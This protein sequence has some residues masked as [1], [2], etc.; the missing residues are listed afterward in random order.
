MTFCK[1]NKG[2]I[3]MFALIILVVIA[4]I[5]LSMK[6]SSQYSSSSSR[7]YAARIK[8]FSASDGVMTLLAQDMLDFNESKYNFTL[9]SDADIGSPSAAGSYK[10]GAGG[11]DTVKGDGS[12]FGGITQTSDKFHFAYCSVSGDFQVYVQVKSIQNTNSFAKAAL[13]IRQSTD[14]NAAFFHAAIAYGQGYFV[15][16]RSSAGAAAQMPVTGSGSVPIWFRITRAGNVF[17]AEKS[18]NGSTWTT[19]TSQTIAMGTQ[20]LAGLGV[21]SYSS[22]NLCTAVFSNLTGL[23]SSTASGQM[24]VGDNQIPVDYTITKTGTNSFDLSTKAYINTSSEKLFGS[25]LNQSIS[26]ETVGKYQ[27]TVHD[28]AFI[29]VTLY[30]FR[31]DQTCPEFNVRGTISLSAN[32]NVIATFIQNTLDSDFKP[33]IKKDAAFR[34]CFI[35][36]FGST[37][38]SLPVATRIWVCSNPDSVSKVAC[39]YNNGNKFTWDFCD[40]MHTWFRPWGDSTGKTGTY[41]FSRTT[42]RWTGLKKRL[43]SSGLPTSDSGWVSAHWDST[44]AFANIVFYDSLKFRELPSPDTGI[45]QFGDSIHAWGVDSQYYVKGC[46]YYEGINDFTSKEWKFMPLKNR[47]FKYDAVRY[48]TRGANACVD[49]LNFGF[50]MEIHKK[51]TYKPGQTFSFRGDDDVWVFINNRKVID[52]GGVHLPMANTVNLDT[53]NLQVGLEYDFDFYYCE[54]NVE[55][56]NILITTNL[57]FYTPPQT[58][59][60]NWKRDYGNLD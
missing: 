33:V 18:S 42:G 5:G 48:I 31:S 59:K 2:V 9:L 46:N 41:T 60:R 30:D 54:R 24:L 36:V 8:T 32:T 45:F 27:S 38:Y 40:S 55:S 53:C 58:L 29:P 3:A 20:V 10:Q 44:K 17:T 22:G 7:N 52:L 15:Q 19:L 56:S 14:A 6:I 47:G 49:N 26:R 23:G 25:N 13:H 35:N 39:Y 37:W 12:T 1:D 50:T 43:S 28:S 21:A 34:N 11:I 4:I 57:L 51:F 16:F